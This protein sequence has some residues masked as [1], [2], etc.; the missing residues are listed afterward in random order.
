MKEIDI[1]FVVDGYE[2]GSGFVT[3]DNGNVYTNVA[4]GEFYAT[5]RKNEKG[6]LR[7]AEEEEKA[8]IIDTLTDEQLERLRAVHAK[9]YHGTD[10]DMPD[11]FEDWLTDLSLPE[12]KAALL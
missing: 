4:E 11:A 7:D 6:W 10:D 9:D 12:L 8:E 2:I 3:I 1:K 5:L